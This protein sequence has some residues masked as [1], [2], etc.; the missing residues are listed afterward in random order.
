MNALPVLEKIL[1]VTDL[2]R[3]TRPVFRYAV[4]L[5]RHYGADLLML[6]VV[7]PLGPTGKFIMETYL[8]D[9]AARR[10]RKEGQREVLERMKERLRLFCKEELDSCAPDEALVTEILVSSGEPSEE[11]LRLAE[12]HGADCIVLGTSTHGLLGG[13]KMGSTARRVTRHSKVPVMLVPNG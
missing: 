4:S 13:R 11:I 6:H 10:F 3:Q 9:E 8:D 12:K 1:Y 5:A 2:G 7:E